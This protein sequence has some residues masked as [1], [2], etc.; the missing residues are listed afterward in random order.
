MHPPSACYLGGLR[1]YKIVLLGEGGVGKSALTMQFVSHCFVDYHDPT[2]EDAYQRQAVIDGESGLLDIL[3]TAGQ[4]EF[5]AMREQY[6]RSGE[7]FVIIYSITDRQSFLEAAQA[8]TQIERVRRGDGTPM[9]LVANKMDLES[10]REVTTEE[11]QA[12]AREFDCPFFET[13]A[14]LRHFVDDVF[15]TLIRQIRKRERLG[16]KLAQKK[17]K[18]HHRA[19]TIVQNFFRRQKK[20]V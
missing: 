9:V 13:S 20:R 8:K 3:D 19:S 7:G 6:M 10:K 18:R 14:A 15:H 11:G 12:L 17:T 5:T 16:M 1:M 2:I 4:Q